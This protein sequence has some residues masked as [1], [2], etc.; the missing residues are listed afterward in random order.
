MLA[1]M[2]MIGLFDRPASGDC[3]Q[4]LRAKPAIE[5]L[6]DAIV[7]LDDDAWRRAVARLREVRLLSPPDPKA[8]E[9]LDAHPLAREWFGERLRRLS[10]AAWKAAHG[11]LYEHLRDKTEEG[12]A[13]TLADLAPLYQ[14]I[15]HGC[16]A[17]RRQEALDDIYIGRICRRLPDGDIEFYACRKLGAYGSE[18]AA[19]SWFFDKPY[20]T[21]VTALN[22]A[23]RS[24]ALAEAGFVLRTQGRF[25]EALAALHAGLRMY[26]EQENWRN[27]AAVASNLSE[28]ELLVGKVAAAV[29]T[30]EQSVAFADRSR[31]KF[32]MRESRASHADALHAAG[33]RE[34]AERLFADAERRQQKWQPEY[35]LLYSMQGYRYCD[36]LLSKGEYAAV[37]DR[38]ARTLD[39]ARPEKD[40]LAIAHDTLTLG[41]ANFALAANNAGDPPSAATAQNDAR[42]AG[43]LLDQAIEGLRASGINEYVPRGLLACAAFWR[44]VGDWGGAARD[45]DEVE[46][47][48]EPVPM[49][50]YQCN[51]ALERARLAFVRLEAFA[52]LNGLVDDSPPKP[53]LPDA[54]EAARLREDATVNLVTARKLIADCGYH[55][56]DEEL[57]E[58]E[59]V[60]AGRR[61]FADLPPRV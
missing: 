16:R 44:S 4:A 39:W 40:I 53:A 61:R 37:R 55:R 27:A 6:T 30:A 59:D 46:E 5:G 17:G 51:A 8:P 43:A 22:A 12:A 41:R 15:A 29:A 3:L 18:L 60:A 25:V 9:A 24:W 11:R 58:L 20:E 57:A 35:L 21:P 10:E 28:T 52:P 56:R 31:S 2:H 36:L 32:L 14:A 23:D 47:I 45:L 1:I 48:A 38:T 7:D 54:A 26:E 42:T 33:E 34:K 13:P 49:R 50:L 19:I